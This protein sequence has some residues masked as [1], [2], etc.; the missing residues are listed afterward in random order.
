MGVWG[1]G[2]KVI[3]RYSKVSD[4]A[5]IKGKAESSW[6]SPLERQPEELSSSP[7]YIT[8]LNQFSHL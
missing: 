7:R 4:S 2:K 3:L 6:F 5:Q 8:L 1:I